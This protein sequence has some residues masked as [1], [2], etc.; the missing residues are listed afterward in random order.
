M[1]VEKK[2]SGSFPVADKEGCK[3][4]R[5]DLRFKP[6]KV[7][8]GKDVNIMDKEAATSLKVRTCMKH[9]SSRFEKKPPFVTDL[10]V[11]DILVSGP[12]HD[13]FCKVMYIDDGFVDT[14]SLE[15]AGHMFD[16]R[17]SADR[18]QCFGKS[19]RYRFQTG[20]QTRCKNHC[21]HIVSVF[22]SRCTIR[23]RMS[24]YLAARWRARCSA[25]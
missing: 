7:D 22:C 16:E 3:C 20:S 15:L 13:L 24:G 10:Y 12:L 9:S 19:I 6:L 25:Q 11:H 21:P 4:I 18:Y 17:C 8:I 5:S 23:T 2:V 1:R 14:G